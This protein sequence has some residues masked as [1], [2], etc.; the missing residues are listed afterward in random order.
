M[1][2]TLRKGESMSH[3]GKLFGSLAF[4]F[5]LMFCVPVRAQENAS[6]VF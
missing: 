6:G 4:L 5:L 3:I 1:Q 2:A